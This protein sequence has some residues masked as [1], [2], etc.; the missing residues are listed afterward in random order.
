MTLQGYGN[1]CWVIIALAPDL[2]IEGFLPAR[3]RGMELQSRHWA[4]VSSKLHRGVAGHQSACS[5]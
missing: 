2:Q 4:Q 5:Q 1:L 3:S